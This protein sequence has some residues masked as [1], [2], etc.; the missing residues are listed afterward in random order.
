MDMEW[1]ASVDA[2]LLLHR[3]ACSQSLLQNNLQLQVAGV[4]LGCSGV[5]WGAVVELSYE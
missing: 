4:E 1:R 3:V 2:Q 5:Q